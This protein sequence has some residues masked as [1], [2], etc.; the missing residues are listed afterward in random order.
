V[1]VVF[2]LVGQNRLPLPQEAKVSSTLEILMTKYTVTATLTLEIEA[3][4]A[5]AAHALA[6]ELGDL[7]VIQDGRL[8]EP[9]LVIPMDF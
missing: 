5:Q 7:V 2:G 1:E 4:D 6:N 3:P 9:K 8:I